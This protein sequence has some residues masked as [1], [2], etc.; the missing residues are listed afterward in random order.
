MLEF[1]QS[2]PVMKDWSIDK[3]ATFLYHVYP[4]SPNRQNDRENLKSEPKKRLKQDSLISFLPKTQTPS[5]VK[6]QPKKG[7]SEIDAKLDAISLGGH[8]C[9]KKFGDGVVLNLDKKEH[10]IIVEFNGDVKK[11]IFPDAFYMGYLNLTEE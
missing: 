7:F 9:H 6:E 2:D 1:K 5:V 8:V 3:F 10:Y 11:F 4:K